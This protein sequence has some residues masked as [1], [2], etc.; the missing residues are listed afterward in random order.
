MSSL[1]IYFGPKLISIVESKGRRLINNIGIPQSTISA[2]ELEERVPVEVKAIEII[3]LFKDELRR[4]KIYAKEAT[5]CLSGKDL[6]IRT[7]EMP[8]LSAEELKTA[9][10]FEVKKYIPFKVEDLISDSQLKFDKISRTNLVLFMGIKK[11]TLDRYFSIFSQLDIKIAGIEYSAFS[12]IRC[13]KLARFSDNGVIGIIGADAQGEDEVNFIVLENGFPL[14]SRDIFAGPGSVGKVEETGEALSLERLKTEIHVSLDYY[15]RKFPTKGIKKIFL[16]AN[17]GCRSELE[18]FILE[19]GLSVQFVDVARYI[20]KTLTFSLSF[21]KGYTASLSKTIKTN[22]R[23]DLLAADRKAKVLKEKTVQLETVSLLKGLN[24]SHRIIALC[25][26]I[27]ILSFGFGLYRKQPLRKEL[28]SL[29]SMRPKVAT[30]NPDSTYEELNRIDSQYKQ[31]LDNL[32]RLIK[33]QLYLTD[34]LAVVPKII[35]NGVW[36]T[37]F[38]F[39]KKEEGKTEVILEGL[40][41]LAD[42]EKEFATANKFLANLRENPE[43]TRYFREIN[44]KSLDRKQL[45]KFT[46]TSFSVSCKNYDWRE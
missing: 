26:L 25:L 13:L 7:F 16:I 30:V 21:I 43:I 23:L 1:S 39:K 15:H 46:A 12:I 40:V 3:A 24:L 6:I 36:L 37:D 38:D 31:K 4:N 32:D 45:E 20:D 44:I 33:N 29:I 9:I 8:V 27:F 22:L 28:N 42:N 5:L 10:N 34:V 18:A 19:R 35:P 14:F 41:Y 2:G 11:E 17:Q